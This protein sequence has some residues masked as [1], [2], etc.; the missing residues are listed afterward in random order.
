MLSNFS[1]W[2]DS[3]EVNFADKLTTAHNHGIKEDI[4]AH[5]VQGRVVKIAVESRSILLSL[6]IIGNLYKRKLGVGRRTCGCSTSVY[7]CLS[8][9]ADN[10]KY[11]FNPVGCKVGILNPKLSLTSSDNVETSNIL[12]FFS[13]LCNGWLIAVIIM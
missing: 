12:R 8:R 1:T 5:Q 2:P 3:F 9:Y 7:T 10:R 11:V 4:W 6:K 13:S